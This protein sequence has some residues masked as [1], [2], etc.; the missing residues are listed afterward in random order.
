[1][2]SIVVMAKAPLPG[3]A[4]TRLAAEVGM[5]RA[6]RIATALFLDTLQACTAVDAE[7]V[8][9]F[10]PHGERPWF[11]EHAPR[12]RLV[13]QAGAD[14]TERLQAAT[15]DA[16]A[17][18]AEQVLCVGTDAPELAPA[19][20]ERAFASLATRAV[21]LGPSLD[22]GYWLVGLARR[23]PGLFTGIPW[24][25]ERV[26]EA[27]RARAAELGLA[28]GEL[29]ARF[30]VDT[31]ADLARLERWLATVPAAR[32]RHVRAALAP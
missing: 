17:R 8:V 14:L 1:M 19:D 4:K 29:D 26:F 5:E 22:G 15:E 13:P 32:A 31:G 30:D 25:T 3:V 28:V 7:L 10:A 27:T 11:A 23:A 12:A 20:L 24:S 18:G 2:R 6:A 21:V 16:F 9:A